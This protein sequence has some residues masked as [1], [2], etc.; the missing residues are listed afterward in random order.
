LTRRDC[1]KCCY[2][3][4]TYAVDSLENAVKLLSSL[5]NPSIHH[6][7]VIGGAQLYKS[8]L[9]FPATDRVLLTRIHEPDFECDTFFPPI[10]EQGWTRAS[11]NDLIK[12]V[13]LGGEVEQDK[14]VDAVWEYQMWTR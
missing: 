6:A 4:D 14:Q 5:K 12:W 10:E 11:W 8:A 3:K 2:R 7:F 1:S 13:D 9:A